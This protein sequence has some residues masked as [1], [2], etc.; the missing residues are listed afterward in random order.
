MGLS[1]RPWH[2]GSNG[3]RVDWPEDKRRALHAWVKRNVVAKFREREMRHGI[4]ENGRVSMFNADL[5]KHVADPVLSRFKTSGAEIKDATLAEMRKVCEEPM[6]WSDMP[7]VFVDVVEDEL[8]EPMT[9]VEGKGYVD[10]SLDES[11]EGGTATAFAP[12]VKVKKDVEP[13]TGNACQFCGKVCANAHGL[14]IHVSRC[15]DAPEM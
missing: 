12:V 3:E 11:E 8:R 1:N 2:K 4:P 6:H 15:P 5:G 10:E 13:D 14:A 7:E 9:F